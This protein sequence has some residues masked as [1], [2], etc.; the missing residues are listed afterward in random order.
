MI[1]FYDLKPELCL[2]SPIKKASQDWALYIRIHHC[3]I[4]STILMVTNE[5]LSRGYF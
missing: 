1:S 5:I 4:G 2:C 3:I